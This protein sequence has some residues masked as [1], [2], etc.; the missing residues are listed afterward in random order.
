MTHAE[1]LAHARKA[2]AR[3]LDQISSAA[4]EFWRQAEYI[5]RMITRNRWGRVVPGDVA[6]AAR[7]MRE[8]E[9]Q[10]WRL[11]IVVCDWPPIP[12]ETE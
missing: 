10:A 4:D 8:Q 1:H 11:W 5:E 6:G 3:L 12:E 9:Q 2:R 7:I